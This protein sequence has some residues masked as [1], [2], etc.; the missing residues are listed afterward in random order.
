MAVQKQLV[1]IE[2]FEQFIALPE[3]SDRL[4]ELIDGEIVEKMS[5]E[6]HGIIAAKIVAEFVFYLKTN[7]I[8]R[9]GVEVRHRIS[10]DRRN[11]LIPDVS[12][13]SSERA[14][15]VTKKGAVP[16]MP[17]LV[18]EI[19]S[20]DDSPLKMREK[21]LY[22]LKNGSR[23][24]ILT[25]PDRRQLEVHTEESVITLGIDDTLD[26]GDVLPGFTLPVKDIFTL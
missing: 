8:G 21:A 16:L 9:A 14:L 12:F 13:I 11:D 20:P 7:P 24:V 18:V 3:N 15:A 5:T 26:G 2:D 25:F 23:M 19:K 6:E 22:Y 10:E 17:D 1:T 4:F